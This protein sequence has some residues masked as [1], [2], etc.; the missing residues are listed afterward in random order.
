MA[1]Q[2]GLE[3]AAVAA[4][5]EEVAMA[6]G[7]EETAVV[8]AIV[9]AV[10]GSGNDSAARETAALAAMVKQKLEALLSVVCYFHC[11]LFL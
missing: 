7:M 5:I 2:Q 10:A 9:E 8:K 6:A 3:E 4:A 11:F 1:R